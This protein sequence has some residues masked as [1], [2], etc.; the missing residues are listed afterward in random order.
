VAAPLSGWQADG[1]QTVLG[2]VRLMAERINAGGG[3]L[4]YQVKIVA[5]DDEADSDVAVGVAEEISQALQEGKK[6]IGVVGHY[7]SGQT[8]AAMEVYKDLP[9]IIVTPTSSDVSITHK[10]YTTFSA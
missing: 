10:G 4:G 8:L 2:G 1:G 9:L 7:N 5:V 3:L 6:V